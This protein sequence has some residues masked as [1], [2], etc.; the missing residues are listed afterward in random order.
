MGLLTITTWKKHILRVDVNRAVYS[1]VGSS[2][3]SNFT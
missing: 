2:L 3:F 1:I